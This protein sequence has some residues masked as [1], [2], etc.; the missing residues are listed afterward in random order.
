VL[1]LIY[2]AIRE[3]IEALNNAPLPG[4]ALAIAFVK[5]GSTNPPQKNFKGIRKTQFTVQWE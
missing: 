3:H 5:S 2:G 4:K 1:S